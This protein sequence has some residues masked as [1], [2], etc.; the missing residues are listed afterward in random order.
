MGPSLNKATSIICVSNFTSTEVEKFFPDTH[1]K[2]HVIH[3]ASELKSELDAPRSFISEPYYLFVGTLEPRKNLRRLLESYQ[4]VKDELPKLVISGGRGWGNLNIDTITE[5]MGLTDRVIKTGYVTD[6][7][8][9]SLYQ[10]THGLAMPSLYEGFGL[11]ALEAMQ[12]G[13]PVI[14]SIGSSIEEIV[15]QGGVMVDPY[16]TDEIAR[17]L[18]KLFKEKDFYQRASKAAKS[19]AEDFSWDAAATATL[20]IL[21]AR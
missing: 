9:Q 7:D 4:L 15:Q 8:L 16:S 14:G 5:E 17:S 12:H 13:K 21:A 1:H 6:S 2:C 18:V 11:P 19:R 20:E 3:E 10:Y